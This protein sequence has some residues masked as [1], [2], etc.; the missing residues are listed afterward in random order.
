MKLKQTLIAAGILLTTAISCQRENYSWLKIGID[1][2]KHQLMLTASEID[3]T[4]KLPRSIWVGYDFA[5][6]QEQLEKEIFVD[7]L[8]PQPAAEKLGRRRVCDIYDWTS[9]FFPGSL[10]YVYELTGDEA[11]KS[12]AAKYTELLNPIREY[13]GTHDLGFMI[14]CSYGNALRLSPNDTI[15]AVLIQTAGNLCSRFNEQVGCILSWDFGHW[16]YPVIIDNMMNLDLLFSASRLTGDPKYKE[17]AVRHADKTMPNHFRE[18]YTC[19][20][21]VS[22]NDDGTVEMNETFQ[23]K[24]HDS[25]WARGQAWAVYGYTACYRETGDQKYLDF[26]VNIADMIMSKVTTKDAIPYWDYDAPV[27]ED[28]PRD[29]S[30]AAVTACGLL[31]LSTFAPDGQKY[32]DYAEKI[33]KSLSSDAYLA[34]PGENQGFVLMHSTGSL[35]HGSEIDVPLNY[36]DYYYLEGLQRYM[37]LKGIEYKNL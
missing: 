9:G 4:G 28:T 33:L 29:A 15:P 10:W 17:V 36:A 11:V 14:N 25:S 27:L 34:A 18:D 12:E 5:K 6:L 2:A 24:N 13:T 32:F 1:R 30:A 7:S 26:A 8:R 19:W 21:V 37:G 23:G 22:Y 3:G 16:N 31:E 35:A 20:H